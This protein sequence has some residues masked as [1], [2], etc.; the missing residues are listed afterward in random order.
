MYL[1]ELA[2]L[3]DKVKNLTPKFYGSKPYRPKGGFIDHTRIDEPY[4]VP[5]EMKEK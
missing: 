1:L 3:M 5:K 4:P 2:E